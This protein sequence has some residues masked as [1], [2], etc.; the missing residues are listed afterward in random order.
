M[1]KE[2]LQERDLETVDWLVG[3][4]W[5]KARACPHCDKRDA[6]EMI[7][8]RALFQCSSCEKQYGVF[9]GTVFHGTRLS[10]FDLASAIIQF[11]KASSENEEEFVTGTGLKRSVLQRRWK[12]PISVREFERL[13]KKDINSYSTILRLHKKLAPSFKVG[14]GLEDFIKG[15]LKRAG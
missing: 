13:L 5:P 1:R 10:P 14:V 3:L 2:R 12:G 6:S 15:L 9:G 11:W 7:R 4:R 8:T